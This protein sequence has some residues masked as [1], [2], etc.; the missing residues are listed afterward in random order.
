MTVSS[1]PKLSRSVD[2]RRPGG[3]LSQGNNINAVELPAANK[4]IITS[5]RSLS[6]SKAIPE[7]RRA[8]PV[9]DLG[10][11]LKP[12]DPVKTRKGK[13]GSNSLS[14][15][16]DYDCDSKVFQSRAML[17]E[18]SS[19]SVPF[20]GPSAK[21]LSLY[22][23]GPAEM[24]KEDNKLKPN[25]V[26]S[27]LTASDTDSVSSWST[28]SGIQ[29]C[30]GSGLLKGRSV[31]RNIGVSARIGGSAKF[32]QSTRFSTDGAMS[33]L[34]TRPASPSKLWIPSASTP[35]RGLSSARVRN[36]A[37]DQMIDNSINTPLNPSFSIDIQIGKNGE[38]QIVDA[39]VSRLLYN[40]YLQWRFTNAK[41][42]ATFMTQKLKIPVECSGENIGTAALG[43]AN[44]N[45]DAIAESKIE[46]NFH[47]EGTNIKNLK[48]AVSSAGD[49][50]QAIAEEM[51]S[52][53]AKL[54]SE[55]MK[56]TVLL[57]QCNDFL[58]AL[59]A[60]QAKVLHFL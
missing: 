12:L 55:T 16:L 43:H 45:Q 19:R 7:R 33:S 36:A 40:R 14:R 39:H 60:I 31:P 15:S 27:D 25:A 26:A 17:D 30:G 38:D 41:A 56:E 20:V 34:W 24:L 28:N 13:S 53:V 4:M 5:R 58:S 42:D 11:N 18:S 3:Q 50:M 37:G 54:S 57:E 51:N 21:R 48:N 46:T 8:S 47:P 2:R 59:A 32:I 10:E 23:G 29:E 35:S 9:S 49:V 22:F 52:L 1:L 44:E 6:V